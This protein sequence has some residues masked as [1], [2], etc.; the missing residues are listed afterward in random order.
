MYDK[1]QVLEAEYEVV[2]KTK[3][4]TFQA[5][6]YNELHNNVE[7]QTPSAIGSVHF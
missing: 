5:Q 2:Q 7:Q 3:M 1:K 4:K 6:L